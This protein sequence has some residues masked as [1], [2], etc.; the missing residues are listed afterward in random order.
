MSWAYSQ[1]HTTISSETPF[2]LANILIGIGTDA[3]FTRIKRDTTWTI[4]QN[5]THIFSLSVDGYELELQETLVNDAP[6]WARSGAVFFK[7]RA[8]EWIYSTVISEG[9][10][11][12]EYEDGGGWHGDQFYSTVDDALPQDY[13]TAVVLTARGELHGGTAKAVDLFSVPRWENTETDGLGEYAPVAYASGTKI[14]GNPRWENATLYRGDSKSINNQYPYYTETG[15][16]LAFDAVE[17][18]YVLGVFGSA[19]GWWQT[20]T[21]PVPGSSYTLTFTV[22]PGSTVTGSDITGTWLGWYAGIGT[23]TN[24]YVADLAVM[25]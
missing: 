24:L 19:A 18:V 11:P 10:E 5:T 17:G 16:V 14:V 3:G 8:G 20:A 22:P 1:T 21:A 2:D 12:I 6:W 23:K 25:L 7:S 13:S 15:E 9:Y 4:Y